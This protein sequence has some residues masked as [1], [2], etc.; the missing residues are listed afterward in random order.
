MT[1]I[2]K[3][4][5]ILENWFIRREWVL[6]ITFLLNRWARLF[7]FHLFSTGN[8]RN[9]PPLENWIV[10]NCFV[11]YQNLEKITRLWGLLIFI[12]YIYTLDRGKITNSNFLYVIEIKGLHILKIFRYILIAYQAIISNWIFR[13]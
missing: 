1:A 2:I 13:R 9:V 8:A 7:H 6:W 11:S 10:Y 4:R 5:F 12:K 3:N